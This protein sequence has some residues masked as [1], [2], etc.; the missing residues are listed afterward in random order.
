[1]AASKTG[2]GKSKKADPDP[3]VHSSLRGGTFF[4]FQKNTRSRIVS[5]FGF[6]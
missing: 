2:K 5:G 6:N 3:Y 4:Y 1:M